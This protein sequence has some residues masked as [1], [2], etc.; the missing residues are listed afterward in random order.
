VRSAK[1]QLLREILAEL[2]D[3]KTLLTPRPAGTLPVTVHVDRKRI[4]QL[5]RERQAQEARR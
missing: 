3:I 2:Q 5:I 4:T 1:A